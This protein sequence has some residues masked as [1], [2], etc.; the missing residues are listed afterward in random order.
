MRKYLPIL[1]SIAMLAGACSKQPALDPEEQEPEN[2]TL[3]EETGLD[4]ID[5]I[6]LPG[7]T[8]M[9][10]SSMEEPVTDLCFSILRNTYRQRPQD[11]LLSPVGV[12]LSLSMAANGTEGDI[13]RRLIGMLSEGDLSLEAVNTRNNLLIRWLSRQEDGYTLY[14]T[15]AALLD[16]KYRFDPTFESVLERQY[17]APTGIL[18]LKDER[19]TVDLVNDWSYRSTEGMIPNVLG[20]VPEDAAAYLLSAVYLNA[21]WKWPFSERN[22][23]RKIFTRADGSLTT[24][25]MMQEKLLCNGLYFFKEEGFRGAGVPLN[26]NKT[27]YFFLPD[28]HDGIPALLEKLQA[29]DWKNLFENVLYPTELDIA[30]PRYD[31]T[32]SINLKDA[33]SGL[34]H[35]DL[36]QKEV[37]TCLAENKALRVDCWEQHVSL[38]VN[39]KGTQAAAVTVAGFEDPSDSMPPELKEAITL[40]HPFLFLLADDFTHAILFAGVYAGM[41]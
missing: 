6:P 35:E 11:M 22:T 7:G 39:E 24:V 29:K 14:L 37:F 10:A 33:L 27:M 3:P 9:K 40:D 25:D 8:T 30:L 19:K 17:F 31:I 18:D 34:G 41:N 26:G 2:I 13:R 20:E 21:S 12:Q 28:S 23:T 36:L 4:V 1:L 5:V 15:Q 38:R 32:S 16:K